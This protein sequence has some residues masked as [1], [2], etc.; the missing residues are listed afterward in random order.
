MATAGFETLAQN[1]RTGAYSKPISRVCETP[2]G[3]ITQAGDTCSRHDRLIRR[4]D[5]GWQVWAKRANA[6]GANHPCDYEFIGDDRRAKKRRAGTGRIFIE[7]R[8]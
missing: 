4:M 6:R 1:V 7:N 8:E 5:K 3:A 2:D